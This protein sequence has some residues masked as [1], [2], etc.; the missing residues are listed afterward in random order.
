IYT[1]SLH[2]ALPISGDDSLLYRGARRV[3]PVFNELGDA[4]LGDRRRAPRENHRRAARK[5]CQTLLEL[6]ALDILS[7]GGA[8]PL[9]LFAS[10]G[11]D[12]GPPFAGGNQGAVRRN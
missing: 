1:L 6:V 7:R 10:R 8:L 3:D 4:L 9:H 2:D 5:F 12:L 11:D